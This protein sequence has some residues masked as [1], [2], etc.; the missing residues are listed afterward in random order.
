[1]DN[2]ENPISSFDNIDL[3]TID[4]SLNPD[5]F[6]DKNKISASFKNPILSEEEFTEASLNLNNQNSP[7]PQAALS[8]NSNSNINI[9][10]NLTENGIFTVD[11]TGEFTIDFLFDAGGYESELGI[12]NLTGMESLNPGSDEFIQEAAR[13]ALSNSANGY[14][15][16][17]DDSEAA[18]FTGELGEKDRNKGNYAGIKTFTMN[19][20]DNFALMLVPQG[21]VEEVLDNP[22]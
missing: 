21:K 7:Q 11:S 22:S 17:N 2:L 12:F 4:N 1:M 9:N 8:S 15:A 14:I 10:S 20:G 16:I 18:R 5:I 13:R 3:F 19:P 6:S